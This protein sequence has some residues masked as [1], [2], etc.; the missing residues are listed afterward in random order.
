MTDNELVYI[1]NNIKMK[2]AI[3]SGRLRQGSHEKGF[4][5]CLFIKCLVEGFLVMGAFIFFFFSPNHPL[6]PKRDIP[7]FGYMKMNA[8]IRFNRWWW[9][10]TK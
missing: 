4:R 2:R 8:V 9:G 1:L 5:T 6:P 10:S 3:R 7:N